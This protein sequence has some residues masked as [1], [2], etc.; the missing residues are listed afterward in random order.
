MSR[1]RVYVSF[2]G[3]NDRDLRARLCDEAKSA[4]SSFELSS[5]SE[6]GLMSDVWKSRVRRRIQAVDEVVVLCGEHTNSSPRVAAELR[7]AQEEG[8]PYLLLW[9][10]RE[11][12][13]TK[14]E[15]ARTSDAMYSWTPDIL[16]SQLGAVL[17]QSRSL[18][19]AEAYK[20]PAR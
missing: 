5:H 12:M 4:A 3:D 7:V 18:E 15:G 6:G 10:R 16:G 1:I 20:R 8:K 17:R 9:G 19:V 13:C 2:D 11:R 14:P